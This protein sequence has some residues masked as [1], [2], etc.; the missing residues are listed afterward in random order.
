MLAVLGFLPMDDVMVEQKTSSKFPTE[1]NYILLS[2]T[3]DNNDSLI[4]Q[5]PNHHK[6]DSSYL[7]IVTFENHESA[8]IINDVDSF[9]T[10]SKVE[11][12]VLT[13]PIIS[14]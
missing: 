5:I 2:D 3:V 12:F 10:S 14:E 7:R 6:T 11:Y 13:D 4:I 9:L 8:M 1:V